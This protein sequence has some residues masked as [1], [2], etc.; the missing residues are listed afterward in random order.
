M[1]IALPKDSPLTKAVV[2][3]VEALV[4]GDTYTSINAKYGIPDSVKVSADQVDA[5]ASR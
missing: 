4:A 2:A 3:A 5:G 1:G